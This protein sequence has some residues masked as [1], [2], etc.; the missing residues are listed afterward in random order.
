[1]SIKK[2]RH[3]HHDVL[4]IAE[5]AQRADIEKWLVNHYIGGENRLR[6]W[7]DHIYSLSYFTSW[8]VLNA[9]KTMP[10]PEDRHHWS[11]T[12]KPTKY[13]N[14]LAGLGLLN[15][16]RVMRTPL[17]RFNRPMCDLIAAEVYAKLEASGMAKEPVEVSP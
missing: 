1:M 15:I 10:D 16:R 17:Y 6:M 5:V 7:T 2:M 11:S 14:E 9:G 8:D 13:L 4:R 3:I 12:A